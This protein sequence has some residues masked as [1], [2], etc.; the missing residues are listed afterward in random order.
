MEGGNREDLYSVQPQESLFPVKVSMRQSTRLILNTI[1]TFGKIGVTIVLSLLTTRYLLASLDDSDWGLLSALG[2]SGILLA[3]ITTSLTF[4]A[5]RHMA[6]EIGRED[7]QALR[8]VFNTALALFFGLGLALWL[9]GFFLTGPILAILEFPKERIS[10]A[11]WVYQITLFEIVRTTWT[12]PFRAAATAR[13]SLAFLSIFETGT[14]VIR[15]SAA[16]ALAYLSG[17][18]LVHFALLLLIG[19]TLLAIALIISCMVRFEETRPRP[20]LFS[21]AKLPDVAGFAGWTLILRI[22][23]MFRLQGGTLL[24]NAVFGTVVN[25]AY[26]IGIQ[27]ASLLMRVAYTMMQV[28]Q[29]AM[30]SALAK[31]N[32]EQVR[33]LCLMTSKYSTLISMFAVVPLLLETDSV[34]TLWLVEY[35]PG[36][37]LFVQLTLVWATIVLTVRGHDAAI[38]AVGNL[39]RFVTITTTLI[40]GA[41]GVALFGS[42]VLDWQAWTFSAALIVASLLIVAYNVL[43]VGKHLR[44]SPSEW[45]RRTMLPIIWST[46]L[47][48]STAAGLRF[49]LEPGI[50]RLLAVTGAYAIL[51]APLGWIVLESIE[52]QKLINMVGKI[53]SRFTPPSPKAEP[54]E[55]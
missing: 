18:L 32:W 10:A 7:R 14:A 38:M 13:Q 55:N 34:L 52:K 5:Q 42:M 23:W 17:D 37:T 1:V 49:T 45:V 36:T 19:Q 9:I 39:S 43:F 28:T 27:V 8:V 53:S 6:Y 31:G 12:T 33:M 26:A 35:P 50:V 4:S 3:L 46:V 11:Y 21:R 41:F 44:V 2:A 15:L 24:V 20:S 16:A 54:S 40:L 47:P 29:P 51:A 22:G 30:T 48:A 25:G